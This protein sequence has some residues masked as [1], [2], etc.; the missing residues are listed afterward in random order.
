MRRHWT[1]GEI[2]ETLA[3]VALFGFLNRWNDSMATPLEPVAT[4]FGS[5]SSHAA[6]GTS[7]S[8]R[9]DPQPRAQKANQWGDWAMKPKGSRIA[10]ALRFA[11]GA[12]CVLRLAPLTR[13]TAQGQGDALL[14]PRRS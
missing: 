11:D 5:E 10:C 4:E 13:R 12:N 14:R 8:T 6:A 7:A 3:V 1:D 9:A 2:V